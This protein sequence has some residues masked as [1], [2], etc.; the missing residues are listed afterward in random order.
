M[1]PSVMFAPNTANHLTVCRR[2]NG[3]GLLQQA[4]KQFSAMTGCPAIEPERKL[5]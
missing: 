5:N 3:H 1:V 2:F 4:I